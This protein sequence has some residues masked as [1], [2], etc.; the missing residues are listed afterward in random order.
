MKGSVGKHTAAEL[1]MG[2]GSLTENTFGHTVLH[3]VERKCLAIGNLC[4][5]D[6]ENCHW[7]AT[8]TGVFLVVIEGK[9]IY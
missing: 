8:P 6:S 9:K 7:T 3:A 5:A 2:S 4:T 1:Y